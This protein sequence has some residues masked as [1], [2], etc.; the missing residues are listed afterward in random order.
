[1][2]FV[3]STSVKPDQTINRDINTP[4]HFSNIYTIGSND[5]ILILNANN[6]NSWFNS[7]TS[8]IINI[9]NIKC[10]DLT[11]TFGLGNEPTVEQFE[12]LFP[13][14]YNTYN[15]G[16]ILL[17]TSILSVTGISDNI[18]DEQAE[19]GGI[20]SDGTLNT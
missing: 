17:N 8:H 3:S 16:S 15:S 14:I 10:I 9:K 7:G 5:T 12:K 1:M 19:K 11:T 13:S 4:W 18:W 6:S 20:S 2:G